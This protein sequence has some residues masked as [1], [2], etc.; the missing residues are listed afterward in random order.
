MPKSSG[1][2]NVSNG[3]TTRHYMASKISIQPNLQ[4]G[5]DGKQNKTNKENQV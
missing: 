4:S 1:A 2:V 5:I 3:E